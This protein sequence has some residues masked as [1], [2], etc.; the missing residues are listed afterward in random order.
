MLLVCLQIIA[1]TSHSTN[2][3]PHIISWYSDLSGY[4]ATQVNTRFLD[5]RQ[6]V[7][8]MVVMCA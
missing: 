7:F 4:I 5:L 6:M 2:I 8:E 3:K 1:I